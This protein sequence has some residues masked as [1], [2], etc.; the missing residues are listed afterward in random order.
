MGAIPHDAV[1]PST[2]L[3]ASMLG[4][5]RNT[6]VI[7]YEDLIADGFAAG[8]RGSGVRAI[9][10]GQS[11]RFDAATLLREAHFPERLVAMEDP[12]GTSMYLRFPEA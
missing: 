3:L 4:V 7:A 5:G 11:P 6:V 1:L 10:I 2:R 8:R 9:G 12:D